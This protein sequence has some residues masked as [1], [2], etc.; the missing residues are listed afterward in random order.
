GLVLE[1]TAGIAAGGSRGLLFHAAMPEDGLLLKSVRYQDVELQMPPEGKLPAAELAVLERWI[2]AGAALPEYKAAARLP[3]QQIDLAEGRRFWSFQ[4]L[5]EVPVP[6]TATDDWVATPLDAFVLSALQAH[7]LS[8][9]PAADPATLL[10][11][12]TFDVT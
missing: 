7:Q 2:L 12:L 9:S 10:R 11:R 1:Q 8:P 3:A 5:T 4:P 6:A